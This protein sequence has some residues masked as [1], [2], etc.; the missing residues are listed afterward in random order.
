MAISRAINKYGKDAFF[1]EEIDRADSWEELMDLEKFYIKH[2][3]TIA[4]NGYNLSFGGKGGSGFTEETRK[5]LSIAATGK[6][7]SP[8]SVEKRS[9][10]LRGKKHSSERIEKTRRS[11][12]L[13]F[14]CPAIRAELSAINIS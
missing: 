6:K 4:P 9:S 7:Q 10:Q 12:I 13:A 8:E 1:I 3:N 11:L 2:F 5:K 14:S